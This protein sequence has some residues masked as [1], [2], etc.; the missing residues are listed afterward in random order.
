MLHLSPQSTNTA[1]PWPLSSRAGRRLAGRTYTATCSLPSGSISASL[2]HPYRLKESGA[3]RADQWQE[4]R[5]A[6]P[7]TPSPPRSRPPVHVSHFRP[8]APV[9]P[10]HLPQLA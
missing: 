2:D 10:N 9:R 6:W 5:V 4:D 1:P 3:V 7:V 8:C